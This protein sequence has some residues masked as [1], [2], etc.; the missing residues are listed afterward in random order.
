MIGGPKETPRIG[1]LL[2]CAGLLLSGLIGAWFAFG[3]WL[4]EAKNESGVAARMGDQVVT[5]EELEK[6]LAPQLARLEEQRYK[7]MESRL[8]EMI[9]E[10]LVAQEAKRRGVTVEELLKA[11]VSSK[12]PEVTEAEVTAFIVQNKSRLQGETSALRPKVREYLE[13][14]KEVQ[15]RRAYVASLRQ[16]AKVTVFLREPEPIRIPVNVEGAFVQGPKDAPVTIVEFSDFQCP[17][18]RNVVPTVKELMRQY[19]A[20]VRWAFRDFPLA[21]LHPK[22]PKAAEA[23]RCAGEQGKFWEYHDLLFDSQAQATVE[24]FKRFAD[25]LKLDP[26]GFASCLDSGRQKAAVQSD[27]EEGARLGITGTPT[28]FINGRMLVG[29]QPLESFRGIIE[30][31]L[32]RSSK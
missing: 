23:A 32:R 12:V 14:E 21:S 4:K 1:A 22:A 20:T 30:A 27:V 3:G 6:A 5:L 7:L 2:V 13:G 19:P 16:A 10:R 17:F 28:F 9:A 24:D 11:E 8:E 26:K 25:Q 15:Q 18:C 29:A 31:E